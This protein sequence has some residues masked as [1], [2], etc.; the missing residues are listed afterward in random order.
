MENKELKEKISNRFVVK[1]KKIDTDITLPDGS[2]IKSYYYT[3]G[4][5]TSISPTLRQLLYCPPKDWSNF[6]TRI[7]FYLQSKMS[8]SSNITV[9][10]RSEIM[11]NCDIKSTRSYYE[12]IETLIN[13]D[14]L[15]VRK[16]NFI[17]NPNFI[18][19][20]N[21][22]IFVDNYNKLYNNETE[23]NENSVCD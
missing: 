18:I 20:G 13:Y 7:L 22:T 14:L 23:D 3:N 9:T 1:S 10:T 19:T 4:L 2:V 21:L 6:A 12:G 8:F 5:S 17:T 11:F 16:H 15:D